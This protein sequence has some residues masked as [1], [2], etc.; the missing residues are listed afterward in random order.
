MLGAERFELLKFH[1][2]LTCLLDS[3][4]GQT[5]SYF[6]YVEILLIKFNTLSLGE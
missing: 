6:N 2:E 1:D 4:S 3:V 5:F